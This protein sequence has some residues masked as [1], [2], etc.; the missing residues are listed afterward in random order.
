M[1]SH[2]AGD[3]LPDDVAA[4]Q[5]LVGALSAQLAERD[6]AVAARDRIID[7]LKSQLAALR[8]HSF[9][10][11]SERLGRAADQLELQIEELEQHQA[12]QAAVPASPKAAT[13]TGERI[14]PIRK[15]LPAHLPR[16][17][18]ELAPP[19][20]ACPGCG[21]ALRRIGED[22]S[23]VLEMVPA[24]L[25]VRRYV[26][27]VM[28]CRCCGDISQAPPPPVP[29][30][31]SS[32]GASLLADIVLAKY[33]DHL[34]AYRQAE[35]FAREGV[36]VPRSTL[37]NW[38]GRTAVLLKPLAERIAA[39]VLAAG[40]LHADD[41]PV[42]VL[43]P[44]AGK[45]RTGRLWVYARDDRACGDATAPAAL[46]R[47]TPDRKGEH[48]QRQLAGWRG[49]LQADGYAGF[50]ALYEVRGGD[51]PAII[52][53]ACWAHVRRKFFDVHQAHKGAAAQE[54]LERIGRLYA[55]EERVRG[56]PAARRAAA[57]QA[58]AAPETAALRTHLDQVLRQVS[59]KSAL[60]EAIRYALSRWPALT[61]Y[62][63]DGRLEI[64]NNIAERAMRAV[65]L[66][67]KNWLFAGSDGGGEAAAVF[68]TLIET[69]KA[70]GHNP[71]LWLTRV[72]DAIGRERDLT[73]YDALLPWTMPTEP[74]TS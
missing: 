71:R 1:L 63:A 74:P 72:L 15:P 67:R 24:R 66:G 58:E 7:T 35:R 52:E 44:G 8:R 14:H 32:A 59:G 36:E 33:D 10:Q 40:K 21:L 60:A 50:N 5:A 25:R 65:A 47:Y 13:P 26:R 6:Q 49:A 11:S 2:P 12:E 42:P 70:N 27:P 41:T 56:Q 37:T 20:A 9:G 16:E 55:V 18:E 22:V 46:Y 3:P 51:P 61:R 30:P 23:E 45:T 17:D 19:Y 68:Y 69:A 29:L 38:L 54:V 48:P 62:L 4:L 53:V 34:P 57:R 64:D 39:H 28:A 43:A 31:K 73:D